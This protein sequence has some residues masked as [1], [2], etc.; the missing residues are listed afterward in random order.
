MVQKL[1]IIFNED[2]SN[3]IIIFSQWMKMLKLESHAL[4]ES[5]IEFVFCRGNVHT[6]SN[7]IKKFK[8]DSNVRVIL[9]S[10]DSCNSGSNLTEANHIMLLDAVGGNV[11]HAKAVENQ[12]VGRA[13]RLGQTRTVNVHRFVIKDSIEEEYYNLLNVQTA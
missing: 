9:L 7:S 8:E 11:E 1:K 6:M 10:S 2:K 12:A 5:D 3:K 13:M 4:R